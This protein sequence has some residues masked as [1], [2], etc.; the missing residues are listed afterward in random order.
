[1]KKFQPEHLHENI[2]PFGRLR[3]KCDDNIK[4]DFRTT[5]C[6]GAD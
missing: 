6:E 5:V 1:M 2:L 3:R 4:M